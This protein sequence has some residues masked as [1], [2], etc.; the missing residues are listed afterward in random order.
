M[1][2]RLTYCDM[3]FVTAGGSGCPDGQCLCIIDNPEDASY[4]LGC[5]DSWQ[6]CRDS[7]NSYPASYSCAYG[8]MQQSCPV[9]NK[10]AGSPL[11]K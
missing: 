5:R 6:D 4:V 10:I 8:S 1:L 11:G 3:H 9:T 2:R 7:C